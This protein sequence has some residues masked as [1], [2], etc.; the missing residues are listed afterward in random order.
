MNPSI[1]PGVIEMIGH[2]RRGLPGFPLGAGRPFLFIYEI[3]VKACSKPRARFAG[4]NDATRKPYNTGFRSSWR[5]R[6]LQGVFYGDLD[7]RLRAQ[8]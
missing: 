6:L 2:Y 4:C 3:L 8:V 7:D 1:L 5:C